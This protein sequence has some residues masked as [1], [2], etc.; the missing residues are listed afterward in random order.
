MLVT[1]SDK[2]L[3]RINVIQSVVDPEEVENMG[4]TIH[5]EAVELLFDAIQTLQTKEEFYAF[6]EDLCTVNEVLSLAQRIEVA[7]KLE[8]GRTYVE[9]TNET[10]ASTATI[11]RVN[12]ILNY[13]TDGLKIALE[14][15]D[16]TADA[17]K[18]S[19]N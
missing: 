12:R 2:E 5:T 15:L 1:M 9:V 13:G 10:G 16:T 7:Q 17:E 11:S 19:E 6:F 4:K 18:D 8:Q 3:S 14:R